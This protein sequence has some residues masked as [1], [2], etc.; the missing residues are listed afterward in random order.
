MF[1]YFSYAN[2]PMANAPI[3]ANKGLNTKDQVGKNE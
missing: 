1:A 3:P 2:V